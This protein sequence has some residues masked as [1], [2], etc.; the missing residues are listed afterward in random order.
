MILGQ[1]LL[2]ADGVRFFELARD[3]TIEFI[4]TMDRQV[5]AIA[6]RI[7]GHTSRISRVVVAWPVHPQISQIAGI[8]SL[9]RRNPQSTI[10][11][12][13]SAIL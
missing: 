9:E 5:I 4:F 13:K 10:R 12:P 8:I 7:A 6:S 2:L 1:V 11:D 3:V